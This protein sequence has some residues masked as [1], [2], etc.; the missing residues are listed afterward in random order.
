MGS[1]SLR[2][3]VVIEVGS[4]TVIVSKR[5]LLGSSP[6]DP[7]EFFMFPSPRLP[8]RLRIWQGRLLVSGTAQSWDGKVAAQLVDDEWE[9]NPP[10]GTLDRNYD[11]SA[12]EVIDAYGLPVLQ[13]SMHAD[14]LDVG[15]VFIA[16]S[17]VELCS[18][19][20][21]YTIDR[22]TTPDLLKHIAFSDS[23][24]LRLWFKYPS[25]RHI[26]QRAD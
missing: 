26:G 7:F 16:D 15:G 20:G 14:T 8:V 1:S 24:A 9:V 21:L 4:N 2:E 17:S 25:A 23:V 13:V 11:N 6:V 18:R 3:D 5:L 10:P 19:T 22:P 12:L